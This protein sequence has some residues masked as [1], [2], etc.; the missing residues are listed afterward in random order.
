M[1]LPTPCKTKSVIKPRCGGNSPATK[2]L[3]VAGPDESV[4][5]CALVR[6]TAV[7]LSVCEGGVHSYNSF[8]DNLNTTHW[9]HPERF[10]LHWSN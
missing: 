5:W 9:G 10:A 1:I 3:V 7:C 6:P 8:K 4:L 2:R